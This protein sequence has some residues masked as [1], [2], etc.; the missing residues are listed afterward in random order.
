MSVLIDVKQ[1]TIDAIAES[2][3]HAYMESQKINMTEPLSSEK[4]VD[5]GKDVE[6]SGSVEKF[7]HALIG[8]LGKMVIDTRRY[9]PDMPSVI[10][11]TFEYGAYM[12]KVR[13]G[14]YDIQDDPM[15][16][17]INKHDYS[18]IEHTFYAPTTYVKIYE[19]KKAIMIA[20]SVQTEALKE[21]FTGWDQMSQFVNAMAIKVEDTLTVTLNAW[22]HMLVCCAIA[23]S[24]EAT[25]T[26]RHLLTEAKNRGILA[27]AATVNDFL[28]S[29]DAMTYALQ[30]IKKTRDR[31]KDMTDAFNNKTLPTYTPADA[32][33]LVMLSDFTNE[34]KFKVLANTYN[35]EDLAIGDYDTVNYWQSPRNDDDSFYKF[36][37]TSQIMLDTD[38]TN[39]LGIGTTGY[40]GAYIIGLAYDRMAI[41]ICPY[42][43]KVTSNYT[44]CAD[45]WNEFLHYMCNYWVDSSYSMVAF[46]L[47]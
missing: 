19:E 8:L 37:T 22:I 32:N 9:Q 43:R 39:K 46:I 38:A 5:V 34:A 3:G 45:F 24:D 42:K 12:E 17:L 23:I 29:E 40:S 27:Q 31:M 41:G 7:A 44:A 15:L 14:L 36:G 18:A 11:D 6:D 21:A 30:E 4:L 10:M 20:K 1:L 2:M 33:K 35:K 47:D 25:G 13:L 28:K 26:A 16:N